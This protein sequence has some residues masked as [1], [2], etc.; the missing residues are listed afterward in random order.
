MNDRRVVA[1]W[2]TR[3][4]DFLELYASQSEQFGTVY[5]YTG[6][7]CGGGLPLTIKTDEAAITWM[8]NPWGHPDG[9]GQCTVLRSDRKSL[10]RV[11]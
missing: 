5:G 1:R 6:N 2:Q 11:T 8:D 3:G 4:K 10:R 7:F 9:T